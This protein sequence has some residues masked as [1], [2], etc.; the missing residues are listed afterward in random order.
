MKYIKSNGDNWMD[1]CHEMQDN[2]DAYVDELIHLIL[3]PGDCTHYE[4]AFAYNNMDLVC[5]LF[6][7][8]NCCVRMPIEYISLNYLEGKIG[9][10]DI[11]PCTLALFCQ[12]INDI[13]GVTGV[14]VYDFEN[15]RPYRVAYIFGLYAGDNQIDQTSLDENDIE[16]A[17]SI[18]MPVADSKFAVRFIKSVMEEA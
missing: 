16:L 15:S 7:T 6:G 2:T 13:N 4:M 12:V 17:T 3:E 5:C 9:R 14:K 11:N 8:D 10:D 18:L 1:I